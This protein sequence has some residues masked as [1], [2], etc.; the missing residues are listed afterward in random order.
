MTSFFHGYRISFFM[1][2]PLDIVISP[3]LQPT[4]ALDVDRKGLSTIT[5]WPSMV[6]FGLIINKSIGY[7]H[8]S[9]LT[10]TSSKTPTVL[11]L[12]L[13]ANSSTVGMGWRLSN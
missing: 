4:K 13:L 6:F 3:Y 1:D 5:G 11:V 8:K 2:A 12:D 10:M 7:Y 9:R